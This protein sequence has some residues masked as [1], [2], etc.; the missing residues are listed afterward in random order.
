MEYNLLADAEFM[1]QLS[2]LKKLIRLNVRN[3]PLQDRLGRNYVRQRAIAEIGTLEWMN[4]S[5]L[6]KY[7]RKDSE[8]FYLKSAFESYFLLM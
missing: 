7:E 4:C 2:G 8:I 6:N 1:S 5:N 3:N